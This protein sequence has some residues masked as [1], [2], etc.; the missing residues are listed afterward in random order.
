LSP[1]V[2]I[3]RPLLACQLAFEPPPEKSAAPLP[4]ATP[5]PPPA[6]RERAGPSVVPRRSPAAATLLP[7]A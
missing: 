1:R 2:K 4:P 7:P 5:V 3:M 6:L